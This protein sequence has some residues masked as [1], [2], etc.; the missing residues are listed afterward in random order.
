MQIAIVTTPLPLCDCRKIAA[1]IARR[2]SVAIGR[3]V[4]IGGA[5]PE[6]AERDASPTAA[7]TDSQSV[8]S[9]EKREP[10]LIRMATMR[11][12]RARARSGI[13]S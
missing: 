10:A 7:I 1:V 12:K 9:A 8:K 11:A 4:R 3:A 13:F 2:I 6:S 5:I